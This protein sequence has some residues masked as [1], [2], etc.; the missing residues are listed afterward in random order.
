VRAKYKKSKPCSCKKCVGYC[1]KRPGWFLPGEAE[2]VAEYLKI[3]M[4][5]LYEK[6]LVIDYWVSDKD[7]DI[8]SPGSKEEHGRRASFGFAFSSRCIFLT[9]PNHNC[10]IHLV[11]PFECL[12][13]HHNVKNDGIHK[14]IAMQWKNK[15]PWEM[16]KETQ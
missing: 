10:A 1:Q 4:K 15:D 16:V 3:S 14:W 7:I 6:Y 12:V 11:K 8:L 2:K 13:A 9:E 5:E